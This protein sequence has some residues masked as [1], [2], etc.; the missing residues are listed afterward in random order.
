MMRNKDDHYSVTVSTSTVENMLKS[1]IKH[2]HSDIICKVISNHLGDFGVEQFFDALTGVAPTCVFTPGQQVLI[3]INKACG[4]K[5]NELDQ[6]DN[7][8]N[9]KYIK[10]IVESVNPYRRDSVNVMYQVYKNGSLE[11]ETLST[12]PN[13]LVFERYD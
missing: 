5:Y 13:D 4:W 7:V 1:V 10:G 12:R 9:G 6:T 11:H 8:V 2:E 3:P